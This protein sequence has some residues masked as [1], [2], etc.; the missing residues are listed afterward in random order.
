MVNADPN[1]TPLP[2]TPRSVNRLKSVQISRETGKRAKYLPNKLKDR[3][4]MRGCVVVV[5]DGQ[6]LAVFVHYSFMHEWLERIV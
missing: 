3:K 5:E 2:M 6:S 1:F 4:W